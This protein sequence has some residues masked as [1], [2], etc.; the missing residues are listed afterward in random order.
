MELPG[1]RQP[2]LSAFYMS[3]GPQVD[4]SVLR[5]ALPCRFYG[6]RALHIPFIPFTCRGEV[7]KMS[8]EDGSL[9]NSALIAFMDQVESGR[10]GKWKVDR[11][12]RCAWCGVR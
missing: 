8:D 4:V 12:V 5:R 3:K 1:D 11:A 6:S 9:L 7:T 2:A 10:S